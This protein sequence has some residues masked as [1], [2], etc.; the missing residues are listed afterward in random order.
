MQVL[1]ENILEFYQHAGLSC[2]PE[3]LR[4]KNSTT[5]LS[6]LVYQCFYCERIFK[7]V[8]G[9]K[10]YTD[11]KDLYSVYPNFDWQQGHMHSKTHKPCGQQQ[12]MPDMRGEIHALPSQW[13][14]LD[15]LPSTLPESS[16]LADA[17][18]QTEVLFSVIQLP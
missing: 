9:E 18:L 4:Q 2:N 5:N 11:T 3:H 1:I 15:T 14:S 8:I 6:R 16:C 12:Q 17:Q 7:N 10:L 13:D